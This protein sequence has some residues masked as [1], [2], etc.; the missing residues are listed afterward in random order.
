MVSINIAR[1]AKMKLIKFVFKGKSWNSRW[2]IIAAVI[3]SLL[4]GFGTYYMAIV[5]GANLSL[6]GSWIWFLGATIVFVALEIYFGH[7][8]GN[9]HSKTRRDTDGSDQ[10]D[11]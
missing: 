5:D 1:K 4:L 9:D 8:A 7:D 11:L 10:Y 3:C 2:V 6:D